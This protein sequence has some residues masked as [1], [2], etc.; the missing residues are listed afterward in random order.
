MKTRGK[1]PPQTP[2]TEET[3]SLSPVALSSPPFV[4]QPPYHRVSASQVRAWFYLIW[5]SWRRQA[6]ASQMVWIAVGLLAFTV[7]LAAIFT[8][9]GAWSMRSWR[10]PYRQGPTF[11]QWADEIQILM[12]VRDGSAVGQGVQAAWAA[13]VRG[14][15]QCSGFAIFSHWGVFLWF[16]SFLLPLLN[17]SFATEALGGERE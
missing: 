7:S 14:M 12:S 16:L 10:W 1:I 11:L 13:A 3:P 4:T 5:L 15:I 9:M 6:R 2:P 17:L 8:A